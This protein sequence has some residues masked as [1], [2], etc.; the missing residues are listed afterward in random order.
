[1]TPTPTLIPTPTEIPKKTKIFIL[2]RLGA[3][4]NSEAI[5]YGQQVNNSDWKMTPFVNNYD[6]LVELLENNGLVKGEDFYVWNY[7]WRKSISNIENDFDDFVDSKSLSENDEIYLIGHSL[8]G[9]VARL[10]AQDN[11]DDNRIKQVINLGSPNMGSL[12]S[13]SVWNGGEIYRI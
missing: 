8:G 4:W 5:V 11:K 9:V 7:D 1:M 13:Y 6:G 12:D 10:W 3:S 2:P